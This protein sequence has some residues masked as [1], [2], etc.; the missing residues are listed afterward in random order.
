M[1]SKTFSL[2]NNHHQHPFPPFSI[3]LP[4]ENLLTRAK[5]ESAIR[6]R[7]DHLTSHVLAFKVGIGIVF[8]SVVGILGVRLFRGQFLQPLLK[9][10]M[11]ASFVVIDE[12]TRRY[13]HGI[14]QGQSLPDTA[15]THR[16]LN[17]P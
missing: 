2:T 4:V 9:V 1:L 6:H 3:K 10:G 17:R 12:A 16:L 7:N 5:I 11:E 15:L 8:C 13:M 14:D